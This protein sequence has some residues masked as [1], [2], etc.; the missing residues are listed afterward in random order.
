MNKEQFARE[1]A[2]SANCLISQALFTRGIISESD[3][4]QINKIL[5]RKYRPMI[6]SLYE[7]DLQSSLKTRAIPEHPP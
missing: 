6:G 5:V 4:R 7:N 3:R 2:Y 1:K